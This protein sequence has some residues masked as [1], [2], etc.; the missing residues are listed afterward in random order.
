[1]AE[2]LTLAESSAARDRHSF[3]MSVISL[4]LI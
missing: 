2:F 4:V 3:V 1:M